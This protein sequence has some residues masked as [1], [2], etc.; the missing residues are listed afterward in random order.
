MNY[1]V[2]TRQHLVRDRQTDLLRR[3]KVYD[4]V[5]FRW[6]LNRKVGGL[7]AFQ[8]LVHI[9]GRTPAQVV[10]ARAVVHQPA[11]FDIFRSCV[12][13]WEPMLYGEVHDLFSMSI[14]DGVS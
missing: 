4:E 13:R 1:L 11:G 8:N 7:C 5:E 10:I 9:G 6:L 2:R 3:F 14:E 12:G